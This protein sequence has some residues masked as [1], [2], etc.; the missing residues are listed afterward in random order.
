MKEQPTL[1]FS[2][3]A[4]AARI[5]EA[6]GARTEEHAELRRGLL[7]LGGLFD[8]IIINRPAFMNKSEVSA[9]AGKKKRKRSAPRRA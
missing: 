1:R 9:S 5:C 8:V 4:G 2:L 6:D 7:G 3:L